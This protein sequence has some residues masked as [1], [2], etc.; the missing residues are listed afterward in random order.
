MMTGERV[1]TLYHGTCATFPAGELRPSLDGYVYAD[2]RSDHA[3]E[4]AT[5]DGVARVLT[6]LVDMGTVERM[7]PGR[8][9]IGGVWRVASEAI[10]DVST[11]VKLSKCE[12]HCYSHAIGEYN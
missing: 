6:L 11:D 1:L 5:G 12:L 10:R 4:W 3:R 9:G 8:N 7:H 2:E